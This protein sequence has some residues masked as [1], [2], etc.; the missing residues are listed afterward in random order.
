MGLLGFVPVFG[1]CLLVVPL[2]RFVMLPLR[3]H[4]GGDGWPQ[5]P[6][7]WAT[8]VYL[9]IIFACAIPLAGM[10]WTTVCG[11]VGIVHILRSDGRLTGL[12]LAVF[13]ATIF[14]SLAMAMVVAAVLACA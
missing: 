3:A 2:G 4:V 6:H 14:P 5:D 11:I 1:T 9:V 7:A 10:L 13:D 12:W 8:R